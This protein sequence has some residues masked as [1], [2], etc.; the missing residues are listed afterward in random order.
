LKGLLLTRGDRPIENSAAQRPGA[1]HNLD[2]A[3][4][5]IAGD[6][7]SSPPSTTTDR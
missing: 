2:A 5:F 6:S 3:V 4:P 7:I 1:R